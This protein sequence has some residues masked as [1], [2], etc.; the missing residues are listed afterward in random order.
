MKDGEVSTRE[1]SKLTKEHLATSESRGKRF[2]EMFTN[3]SS[4]VQLEPII[5]INASNHQLNLDK[6]PKSENE[7]DTKK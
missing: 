4:G 2:E 1:K 7:H 6:A 5:E 3:K